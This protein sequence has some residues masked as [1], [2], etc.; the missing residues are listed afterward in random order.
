MNTVPLKPAAKNNFL[1]TLVPQFRKVYKTI[2]KEA[3][4]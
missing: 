2:Y 3:T 4:I 1:F